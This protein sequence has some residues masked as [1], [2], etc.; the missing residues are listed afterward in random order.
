M[1]VRDGEGG[2]FGPATL[3]G[4]RPGLGREREQVRMVMPGLGGSTG[5]YKEAVRVRTRLSGCL[6]QVSTLPL[7]NCATLGKP[8]S[9]SASFPSSV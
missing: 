1:S 6:G 7:P 4:V 2:G 5:T 8:L 3:A 9:L